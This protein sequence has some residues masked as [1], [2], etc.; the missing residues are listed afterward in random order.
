[1]EF[2]TFYILKVFCIL[3][4]K[5]MLVPCDRVNIVKFALNKDEIEKLVT[6]YL[7]IRIVF[8]NDR[9][10]QQNTLFTV[11]CIFII[12]F[13]VRSFCDIFGYALKIT[14][15]RHLS[16]IILIMEAHRSVRIAPTISQHYYSTGDL[17]I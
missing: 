5:F 16:N 7:L 1:M 3:I 17:H 10:N 8:Y 4:F 6:A 14:L 12:C 11:P 15:S 2:V 13:R 9:E